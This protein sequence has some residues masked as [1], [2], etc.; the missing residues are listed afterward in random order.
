MVEQPNITFIK[1]LTQ[2][3]QENPNHYLNEKG[4]D[5]KADQDVIWLDMESAQCV[6][7]ILRILPMVQ[8]VTHM[9]SQQTSWILLVCIWKPQWC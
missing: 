4:N 7:K 2:N 9:W 6:D 1:L 5:I 3:I 8:A